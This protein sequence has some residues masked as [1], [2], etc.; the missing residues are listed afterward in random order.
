MRTAGSDQFLSRYCAMKVNI[1]LYTILKKY[2]NGKIDKDNCVSLPAFETIR[3]L[4]SYLGIPDKLGKV[5][6]INGIPR[7]GNYILSEGDEVKI[8]SFIGGG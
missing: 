4:T 6:L 7:N 8:L 2:G 5:Y 3:G 1:K